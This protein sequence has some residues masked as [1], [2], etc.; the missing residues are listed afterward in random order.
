MK[1]I[2]SALLCSLLIVLGQVFWKIAIDKSGGLFS[3]DVSLLRSS[4]NLL[5]SPWM[6][7]G[8]L[9]YFLATVY[10]VYLL[11][12]YEYSYIYPLTSMVYLISFIFAI[13][14][15]K[16]NVNIYRWLGVFLIIAGVIFINHGR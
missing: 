14:V 15:F 12:K 1:A 3:N 7:G 5:R 6:I 2:F 11:S 13:F 4:L 8:L 9:I 10:W 16:E